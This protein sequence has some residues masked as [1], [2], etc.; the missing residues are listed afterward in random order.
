MS[1]NG[2]CALCGET[3]THSFFVCRVCED[4]YQL[5]RPLSQW[6]AWARDAV[7]AHRRERYQENRQAAYEVPE[8]ETEKQYWAAMRGR[9]RTAARIA[10]W[11]REA[12]AQCGRQYGA[13][14]GLPVYRWGLRIT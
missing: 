14:N 6:E 1:A 12:A 2:T 11:E 4:Q 5:R 3:I 10:W 9:I 7:L 13:P 8:Y